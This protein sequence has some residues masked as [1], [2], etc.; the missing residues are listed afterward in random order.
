[1]KFF[2]YIALSAVLMCSCENETHL[3]NQV[4]GSAKIHGSVV[5]SGEPV[6]AATILLT[7][8]GSVTFTGS[9]GLY[10]FSDLKSGKYEIKVFKEGYLSSNQTVDISSGD[11]KEV[12]LMLNKSS[13][14]LSI[15]KSYID[16]GSNESNNAA[17]FSL[18]NAGNVELAWTITKAVSWITKIDP[19]S[20]TVPA[21]G[22]VGVIITID[23]SKLSTNTDDNYTTLVART[24][25]DGSTPELL[26]TVFGIGDGTNTTISN[27]ADYIVIGDLYVQTKDLGTNLDWTSAN[28]LCNNAKVGGYNDWR[29][30]TIDELATLYTQKAA[31]GG[32][33]N[34]TYW[35]STSSGTNSYN[36]INFTNG[37][38]TGYF[39]SSSCNV[40]AVR[41]S[42]PFPIVSTLPVTN[43]TVNAVT[44]NGTINNVGEPAFTERGFVYSSSFQNP[45][46]EDNASA[47]TKCVVPGT[48]TDFSVNISGL[49][50]DQTYYVRAYTTNSNGTVYGASI[51][52]KPTVV[53]DYVVLQAANIMVRKTDITPNDIDWTSANNLCKNLIVGG[54]TDWRLPTLAELS[55]IYTERITIDGFGSFFYWTS[56]L[57]NGMYCKINFNNGSTNY[58]Y[59]YNSGSSRARAVR[60]I[61]TTN[62]L[63]VLTTSQATNVTTNSATLGGN[64]SDV[65]VPAY[66]EKGVCYSTSQTPTISNT[67]IVVTGSGTGSYTANATG[68]SANTTYFVRAYATNVVGPAYGAQVSFTT[69]GANSLPVLTTSQATNITVNSATLGGNI[70]NVGVPAYTERGVCYSTSSNPT[71]SNTKIAVSGSGT[72]SYT[73]NATGLLANTTY[74][75]RAYATNTAG[76]TYGS[77]VSF[78]TTNIPS[79]N[80]QVRFKK[81]QDYLYVTEMAVVDIDITTV[82]ADFEFGT[83]L[84]T[85]PYYEIPAGNYYPMYYYAYPGD[86]GWD[87]CLDNPYTFNFQAGIKYTVVCSDDGTYLTFSVTTDGAFYAP[88]MRSAPLTTKLIKISKSSLN[89]QKREAITIDK[90]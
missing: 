25:T 85:T 71:I 49:T 32:F 51:N 83:S 55:T 14:K 89:K 8:G 22:Q 18:I 52:F 16:M 41:K 47:T 80:A 31:I 73:A 70:S 34:N 15:N 5:V 46:I 33:Q 77:Q 4:T 90:K 48:S 29:L 30:P 17:G 39:N 21:N 68:L 44:L 35:S 86:E 59:S 20:G 61:S 87:F 63:P 42:S 6:N 26:V 40:R 10:G 79:Q 69:N 58:D 67:K 53:V 38:R 37:Q 65:G 27:N 78:T 64:I 82:F 57:T 76:P 75:V 36:T 11:N 72:G 81:E 54:Y 3:P 45:A 62:T 28:T 24:T 43:L 56:T 19:A 7:P 84:G 66:T 23:R 60:T 12:T 88:S 1:M 50:T 9:D 13:G 2:L 74:Y